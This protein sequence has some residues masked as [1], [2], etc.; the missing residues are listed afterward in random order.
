M[1]AASAA[2]AILVTRKISDNKVLEPPSKRQRK[3]ES[4]TDA[5]EASVPP[6]ASGYSK[7][8]MPQSVDSTNKALQ[9][10]SL[11]IVP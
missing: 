10:K 8:T 9:S 3:D 6:P 5:A 2:P 7:L 1:P 4:S 11:Q